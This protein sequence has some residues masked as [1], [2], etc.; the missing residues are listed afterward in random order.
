MPTSPYAHIEFVVYLL[1]SLRPTSI[2]DI[3]LGNGKMG[4]IARDLLDVMFGER[5]LKAHWTTLIDGIEAFSDYIQAHQRFIYDN[6]FIGDAFELIDSLGNYDLII[7]GDVLEHL[8]KDRGWQLLDKCAL[9]ANRAMIINI[10]LGEAP[11]PNIY[12]NE[13][14]RHRASWFE[15]ELGP[16]CDYSNVYTLES[17]LQYGSFLVRRD[18]YLY[19]R[20]EVLFIAGNDFKD[21]GQ[22]KEAIESYIYSL[23]LRPEVP[24]P[25]NN[26]GTVYIA[27]QRLKEAISCF[28]KALQI[29][30]DFA[31][32]HFN[33][34]NA[35]RDSKEEHSAISHYLRAIELDPQMHDAAYNLGNLYQRMGQ[36]DEALVAFDMATLMNG[37]FAKAY[38]NSGAIR[39]L[40]G[41]YE[42]A[43]ELYKKAI[44]LEPEH[45]EAH[46]NLS[47][48]HLLKGNFKD[49]WPEYE[50]RWKTRDYRPRTFDKPLWDGKEGSGTILLHAEQGIG[51][52]IHFVRYSP[53]VK[54]MGLKVIVQCHDEL[55]R[56]FKGI[57]G[58]DRVF[59][60][61]DP[62]PYFDFHCP[63]MTLPLLFKTDLSCI[64]ADTPYI[65]VEHAKVAQYQAMIKNNG[66]LKV[67]LVWAG[68]I[69]FTNNRFRSMS[70]KTLTPL[71]DV[72]GVDFYSL[73]KGPA[74]A[75]ARGFE[76][77]IDLTYTLRDFSDTAG[78]ISNL[79]LV[80]SVDT[81][82]AHLAGALAKPVWI[83]LP[84][85][86]D[87]RWM[88]HRDDSPWY[89]TARLFRQDT[90]NDWTKTIM[91]V[92]E[93][94]VSMTLSG[95][96]AL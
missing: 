86:P 35:Y 96:K 15:D 2:L 20:A 63:L 70:L 79:D 14:E 49:G 44:A 83:M 82:V 66:N 73:Q 84:Y 71:F 37:S 9:H 61:Q 3:G 42:E 91:A 74:S 75:E 7:L 1:S 89:P 94:L 67:G 47:L 92:K 17:G 22:F 12:N 25:Y 80:I 56:L 27:M 13:F 78:L 69:E 36:Y 72:K 95:P 39:Y 34:A 33:L 6:I 64:P 62:L 38:N 19:K 52:A 43:L 11:Q 68:K 65:S 16:F 8:E 76:N 41:E 88:L 93:S 31:I 55:V 81:A 60:F 53:M 90:F 26:L 24:E 10:P 54:A 57:K 32:A 77:I 48:L 28:Q 46:W 30:Q 4:F 58:I 23:R 50:W 59:G 85:C 29:N 18:K 5:Y 45:A 40:R 21:K 87:W 51:D